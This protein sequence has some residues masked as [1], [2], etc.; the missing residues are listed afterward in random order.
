MRTPGVDYWP[1]EQL[2]IEAMDKALELYIKEK[3]DIVISHEGPRSIAK[4]L[5]R[6]AVPTP[7]NLLL[8]EMNKVHK[9]RYWLFGHYHIEKVIKIYKT[10]YCAVDMNQTVDIGE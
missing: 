3:P 10:T 6:N 2:S 7:T 1:K 5:L 4:R 8:D 9:P